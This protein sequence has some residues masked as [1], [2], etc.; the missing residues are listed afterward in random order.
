MTPKTEF[1]SGN[2]ILS[3]RAKR[4]RLNRRGHGAGGGTIGRLAM[5]RR[6]KCQSRIVT[7]DSL[8]KMP[9][10]KRNDRRNSDEVESAKKTSRYA[11]ICPRFM[12][13]E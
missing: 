2:R 4:G 6:V 5:A 11:V 3:R 13:R 8:R 9:L 1:D 12:V 10:F 7:L